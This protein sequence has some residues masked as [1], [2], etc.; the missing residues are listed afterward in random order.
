MLNKI[1]DLFAVP[2]VRAFFGWVMLLFL[3]A[4]LFFTNIENYIF[5]AFL[6][7]ICL[8]WFLVIF[9]SVL[10]KLLFGPVYSKS[11]NKY[12]Y[13]D[14]IATVFRILR[15]GKNQKSDSDG[16]PG[17]E[18]P[19][20]G[21]GASTTY[22]NE[23][24]E[25][26][27]IE[28]DVKS[29]KGT[30][31]KAVK[32]GDSIDM[33]SSP[34]NSELTE[35]EIDGP[36]QQLLEAGEENSTISD[37]NDNLNSVRNVML[38]GTSIFLIL[39]FAFSPRFENYISKKTITIPIVQEVR[40]N[41]KKTNDGVDVIFY[42]GASEDGGFRRIDTKIETILPGPRQYSFDTHKSVDTIVA[43]VLNEDQYLFLEHFKTENIEDEVHS[44]KARRHIRIDSIIR[45]ESILNINDTVVMP[46]KVVKDTFIQV[47]TLQGL[48]SED[49]ENKNPLMRFVYN[50]STNSFQSEFQCLIEKKY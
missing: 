3:V 17:E 36:K 38:I 24:G 50:K 41:N 29:Q 6:Q 43:K 44:L 28:E 32:N 7:T 23:K 9:I 46:V 19:N 49:H 16:K 5:L 22:E 39:C 12:I 13:T 47:D 8:T 40:Y 26:N 25:L 15:K 37:I 42:F 14:W 18:P 1:K 2:Q 35:S 11:N 33:E 31:V 4:I 30:V 10:T 48:Y 20:S 34:Q 27:T 45:S 21:E